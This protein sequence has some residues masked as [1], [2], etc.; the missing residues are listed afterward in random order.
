MSTIPT[1]VDQGLFEAAPQ[2]MFILDD[3]Q[4]HW[5]RWGDYSK[6]GVHDSDYR[7]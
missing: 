6:F 2:I 7:R 5:M 1:R 4:T 3:E